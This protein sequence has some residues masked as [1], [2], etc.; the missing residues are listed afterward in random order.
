MLTALSISQFTI[1]DK[2]ELDFGKG[3]TA[4]TGETGA[5]KSISL[6]ALSLALGSRAD[7]SVVRSGADRADISALFDIRQLNDAKQWLGNNELGSEDGECILRR[8]ISIEG[9][10]KAYI[11]GNP[12]N[13]Q[14]LRELGNML[15]G[16]HSQHA[17]HQLLKRE[18]HQTLLDAFADCGA[19]LAKVRSC[20]HS[21]QT[22]EKK[23]TRLQSQNSE[24]DKRKEFVEFQLQEFEQLAL[25][26]DEY[27]KL[28]QQHR[29]LAN[30]ESLKAACLQSLDTCRDNE[31][32]AILDQLQYCRQQLSEFTNHS[33][34]VKD[35]CELLDS[36]GIQIEEAV[37]SLR[38]QLDHIDNDSST[39]QELESRLAAI[40]DLARKHRV[41]AEMLP[42]IHRELL[43]ERDNLDNSSEH[44]A[45]LQAE[46]ALQYEQYLSLARQL[47]QL[48]E[49]AA[50][51][52]TQA[53]KRQLKA[54]GMENCQF[55]PELNSDIAKPRAD[56][57]ENVEFLISTNPGAAAQS[58]Q[59]IA[60][61]GELSRI[62]L[63]IQVITAQASTIPT[64]VFD[65]VDVGIGGATAD[66]VGR[67][68]KTLGKSAQ[69]ICVTH[70]PQVAAFA[71]QHFYVAKQMKKNSVHTFVKRLDNTEKVHEIARM[72]GGME[73]TRATLDHASEMLEKAGAASQTV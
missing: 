2:L 21:W 30:A 25:A 54:L 67:L 45:A 10:S 72:L 48:R 53:V 57:F 36:A 38:E 39:L 37:Q 42:E 5:G 60:S 43:A 65:E 15:A 59:K 64:L 62:S 14:Q 27:P 34:K 22:T 28:E 16:I 32:Q 9:R 71:D 17:H 69:I 33:D 58:L 44:V 7:S 4:I 68:L 55:V 47:S 61:G 6:D 50:D 18:Y 19:L 66:V 51:K 52:L 23:I 11:N 31:H 35:A 73:I 41:T 24:A 13:L 63:A 70:L 56:G 46:S 20:F 26:D 29:L 8:V 40:H 1:A 3:M 49:T 12:V